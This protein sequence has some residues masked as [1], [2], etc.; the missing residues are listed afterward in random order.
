MFSH[1]LENNPDCRDRLIIFV[2]AGRTPDS[3]FFS[4]VVGIGSSSHDFDLVLIIIIFYL[5][6]TYFIE[7]IELGY[8]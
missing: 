4:N 6:L 7:A 8:I 5:I 1:I 2:I 3:M